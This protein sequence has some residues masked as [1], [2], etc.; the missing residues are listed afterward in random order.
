VDVRRKRHF[1]VTRKHLLQRPADLD[2]YTIETLVAID[3]A[4]D[5]V[6][7][8]DRAAGL[9]RVARTDL[10]QRVV[11]ARR[12]LDHDLDPAAARLDAGEPGIDHAGVVEDDEVRR[13]EQRGQVAKHPVD[14]R[15]AIAFVADDEQPARAALGGRH[16]RD[17]LGRKIEGEIRKVHARRS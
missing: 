3:D 5:E 6:T 1:A 16:L 7:H 14:R 10:R 4:H 12:S 17:Q 13:I 8:G 15:R 9:R 2:A 11:R